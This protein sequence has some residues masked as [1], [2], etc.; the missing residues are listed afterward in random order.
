MCKII[1]L[2]WGRFTTELNFN[3]EFKWKGKKL[4][5]EKENKNKKVKLVLGP[6][7]FGRPI[8]SPSP[9]QPTWIM[10]ADG[11]APLGSLL[12]A[13][14]PSLFTSKQGPLVG[15]SFSAATPTRICRRGKGSWP[16]SSPLLDRWPQYKLE[17]GTAPVTPYARTSSCRHRRECAARLAEL[18]C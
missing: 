6:N 9:R 13:R 2:I 15:T 18:I 3:L 7:Q 14:V 11:W 8:Y 5:K 12:P 1:L 4:G 10:C 16:T 17:L